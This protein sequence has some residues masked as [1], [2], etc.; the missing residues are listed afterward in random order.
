[1]MSSNGF[2]LSITLGKRLY[3]VRT[4]R[5][6]TPR[7]SAQILSISN[8]T[9]AIEEGLPRTTLRSVGQ[10]LVI[11][12]VKR[13]QAAFDLWLTSTASRNEKMITEIVA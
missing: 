11:W 9:S 7:V 10:M 1:M 12:A 8:G 5:E 13:M 6:P 4:S 2:V 3:P